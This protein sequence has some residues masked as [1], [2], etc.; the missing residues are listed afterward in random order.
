MAGVQEPST[1]VRSA[2]RER[3]RPWNSFRDSGV[4]KGSL[5]LGF[6]WP[7]QSFDHSPARLLSLPWAFT[8]NILLQFEII[9]ILALPPFASLVRREPIFPFKYLT[10][11]Y[12]ALGL[13]PA[14]RAASLAHHYRSLHAIFPAPVLR[15]I[16]HQEVTLLEEQISGSLFSV[17][18]SAAR[19]VAREWKEGEL[20]LVLH[21]D[22]A[23][24]YILQFTIVPGWVV[25]S[26]APNVMLI[27]RL[28]GIRGGYD[29]VRLATKAFL[30]V[31][32]P[33]LLLA[34]LQ[35]IAQV[36]GI[37]ELAG[38]SA[39]GQFSYLPAYAETF[40]AIYDDFWIE[41]GAR[42]ISASF[43][44]SPI[45]PQEKSLAT[46]TNGHKSRTRKKRAFKQK[47]AERVAR[48]LRENGTDG[49]IGLAPSDPASEP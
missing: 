8:T 15:R 11:G 9:R 49:R 18:L 27:S 2:A 43:Y 40:R 10:R 1:I 39:V 47:I 17:R 19:D 25:K 16:L 23:R 12:L 33:A 31:A 34:A 14:E 6:A 28:Q 46:I 4:G 30:E 36:S 38:V 3:G 26:S 32:P 7:G 24:V 44:A 41:L 22:G 37:D 42:K 29:Q 20:T 13:S 5:S 21:V 35:G 45:P 48:L